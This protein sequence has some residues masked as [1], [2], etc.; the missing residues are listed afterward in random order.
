MTKRVFITP[1]AFLG[2]VREMFSNRGYTIVNNLDDADILCLT[3]GADINPQL[4]GEAPMAGTY[5]SQARDD[6]EVDCYNKAIER[7]LFVFGI[8]RGG[9]LANVLNGGRLW[10]HIEGHDY[11][12]D[13]VDIKTGQSI[14]TSSIHHQMFRVTPEAEVIAVCN[15]ATLKVA[16]F[17]TWQASRDEPDDDVEICFYPKSQSLCIQGHPEVGPDTFTN[18]CFELM[19]SRMGQAKEESAPSAA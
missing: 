9:Q 11:H 16:K 5:Y 19:E 3:G 4:Y 15:D 8:C 10:Q 7:G 6:F 1:G 14:I 18:Y 12:H 17:E 13:I 2:D